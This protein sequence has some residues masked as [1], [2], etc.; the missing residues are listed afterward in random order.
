MESN[1]KLSKFN[2]KYFAVVA[3]ISVLLFVVFSGKAPSQIGEYIGRLIAYILFPTLFAWLVWRFAGR[4]EK[5]ASVTFN[6]V[7]TLILLSQIGQFG[8]KQQQS[9]IG[10]ELLEHKA[11]YKNAVTNSDDPEENAAAFDK[12][13]D[14]VIADMNEL[15]ETGSGAEKEFFQFMSEYVSSSQLITQD[16]ITA[17]NM[18]Q[19]PRIL[20]YSL[21]TSSEEFDYQRGII[22]EYIEKSDIYLENFTS[23]I[24]NLKARLSVWGE[25]NSYVKDAI[26][27]TK[28][29]LA[30]KPAF[31][32]LMQAHI[33]YG[34][35]LIQILDFLQKNKDK[36]AYE[37]DELLL[38]SDEMVSEYNKLATAMDNNAKTINTLTQK[39]ID[40]L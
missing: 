1:F 23:M 5:A 12:F 29:F 19:S 36:W 20:D 28:K 21:L 14:A 27:T 24:P 32:P 2:K 40:Q 18:V 31:E 38:D 9:Q 35:N 26:A 33:E 25:G 15:S 10:R 37:D 3:L 34:N 22:R 39:G 7:L 8:K 17:S 30:L 11:E 4:K 6:I 16:W 13:T